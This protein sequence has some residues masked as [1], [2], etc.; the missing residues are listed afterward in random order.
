MTNFRPMQRLRTLA[1]FAC[2]LPL[3][4]AQVSAHSL[5]LTDTLIVLKTDGTFQVDMTCDLDALALGA[6]QGADSAALAARLRALPA[7]EIEEHLGRLRSYFERRVRIRL[8]GQRDKQVVE[9]HG[10]KRRC[11]NA[12]GGSVVRVDDGVATDRPTK[13]TRGL[14]GVHAAD[15]EH[16]R[17]PDRDR[18]MLLQGDLIL[19]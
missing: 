5:E 19:R 18:V 3:L 2:A 17:E 4:A 7:E 12:L 8:P 15:G 16:D 14:R 13:R 11:R 6:P 9:R 10:V 1:A